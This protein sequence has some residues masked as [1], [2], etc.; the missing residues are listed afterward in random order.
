M[1]EAWPAAREF[2]ARERVVVAGHPLACI[3]AD[4]IVAQGGSVADAAIAGAAVLSVVLPDA[5][6]LGGDALALIH[7]A[8]AKETLGLNASGPSPAAAAADLF[9]GGV[10]TAGPRSMTV[11]GAV[12]GWHALHRRLGRLAWTDLFAPAI[13][14]A[15][16]GFPI[17]RGLA[18]S[19]A[20]A[21]ESLR[22]DQGCRAL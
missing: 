7:D 20:A 2:M 16:D 10:P 22:A 12:A 9:A 11:P 15:R 4:T 21:Q 3:A 5:C 19:I 1:K 6:G 14:F 8:A 18:H 17:S 13:R